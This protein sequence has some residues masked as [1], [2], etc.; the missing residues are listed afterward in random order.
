MIVGWDC[1]NAV[2]IRSRQVSFCATADIEEM[3]S[4]R[5]EKISAHML[6]GGTPRA[7]V[8]CVTQPPIPMRKSQG[9]LQQTSMAASLIPLEGKTGKT[10]LVLRQHLRRS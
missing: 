10:G 9:M 3:D 7:Q 2:E 8:L 6:W 4:D 1:G 5:E